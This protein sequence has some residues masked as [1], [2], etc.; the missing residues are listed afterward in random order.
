MSGLFGFSFNN[1]TDID[2]DEEQAYRE[3]TV[4]VTQ[5]DGTRGD[6]N[7]GL[8]GLS[9][10]GTSF[11]TSTSPLAP[12]NIDGAS[13]LNLETTSVATGTAQQHQQQKT[14]S[15]SRKYT[16][17][18]VPALQRKQPPEHLQM[19]NGGNNANSPA[20]TSQRQE[21]GNIPMPQGRS[22]ATPMA[23][24]QMGSA[25]VPAPP[26]EGLRAAIAQRRDVFAPAS[27]RRELA[28]QAN[29][30][31][32]AQL[33]KDFCDQALGAMDLRVFAYMKPGTPYVQFLHSAATFFHPDA[34]A[35]LNG[36]ALGF[37]GD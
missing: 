27:Q 22:T 26:A 19:R 34:A 29:A 8:L 21:A 37:T 36:K 20:A 33:T 28:W 3:A 23:H 6:G 1:G 30:G 13:S 32:N 15:S 24:P 17:S 14:S 12:R 11:A 4:A 10:A 18:L 35:E 7:N 2:E 5:D 31:G 9:F 25:Y 16:R